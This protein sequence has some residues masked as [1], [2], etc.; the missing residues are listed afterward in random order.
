MYE[1]MFKYDA[2][3]ARHRKAPLAQERER[4]LI[5][6]QSEGCADETLIGIARELLCIVNELEI[7]SDGVTL[8]R[9]ESTA[10]KWARSQCLRGR[11]QGDK[12]SRQRFVQVATQ[13][14]R[15]LGWLR[16]PILERKVFADMIDDFVLW[17]E[18]ERGLSTKT[19]RNYSWHTKQFLE[20]YSGQERSFS[21]V[22]IKDVDLFLMAGSLR[23]W[24]R[25]SIATSAKALR[26]FFR[27][28]GMRNWC[29]TSI[30]S[31][32]NG[33]RLFAEE[34]LPVGPSWNDVA[35]LI[36][37]LDTDTERDIRDRAIV[38]LFAMYGFRSSEVCRLRLDDIDWECDRIQVGRPKQRLAQ[39]YPLVSIAGN[40][41]IRYLQEVRPNC[42]SRE[43][44][45]TLKAP[46]RLLSAG[47]MHHAIRTRL[48]QLAIKSRRQGPH[49]LR[50]A[51][52][53]HLVSEG[54]SLKEVGDHLGHRSSSATRIYAKVNLPALREVADFDLGGLL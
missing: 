37:W 5:H 39:T 17:M 31:A 49:A 24:S 28:A 35:R 19:I 7:S 25:V 3:I 14:L 29:S 41:I 42:S 46:Y 40:A 22:L 13:W 30:A 23:G 16:E 34:A 43:L 15:F 32:I 36:A 20:W 53:A 1:R 51:C 54:F 38:V 45:V 18:S 21:A 50:H 4:Y 12:W 2:V 26:A 48:K 27:H 47:A 10:L 8:E 11:A 9:I 52:A 6:R 44:F 33:P